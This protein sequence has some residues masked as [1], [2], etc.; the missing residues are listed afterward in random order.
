MADEQSCRS[1]FL[2]TARRAIHRG[3][4]EARKVRHSLLSPE[5][6]SRSCWCSSTRVVPALCRKEHSRIPTA[7]S[8]SPGLT[9]RPSVCTSFHIMGPEDRLTQQEREAMERQ[10]NFELKQARAAF[11]Y[12][13]H[14]FDGVG[15]E[16]RALGWSTR[17]AHMHFTRLQGTTTTPSNSTP[18]QSNGFRTSFLTGQCHWSERPQRLTPV[19]I[20]MPSSFD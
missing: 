2:E 9:R 8:I 19:R 1:N 4:E 11:E 12:A 10:L 6:N 16:A 13:K 3:A 20:R 7:C 15:A 5:C 18:P 14:Q 17:M